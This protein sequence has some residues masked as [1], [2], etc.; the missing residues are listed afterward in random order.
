MRYFKDTK[1]DVYGYDETLD[2]QLPYIQDAVSAG[3]Q[4]IT[5][6]WPPPESETQLQKRLEA[7]VGSA[8]NEGA[9]QW[10]Y[11]SIES[12]VSYVNSENPQYVAEARALSKWRD[13]VWD[14]AIPQFS[15]AKPGETVGG[16]LANMPDF[17]QRPEI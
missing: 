2:S 8:I 6:S 12:A 5:G 10:G 1:N 3:W 11:D 15:L 14:W 4:E 13:T 16:F 17:P 9:A 7:V